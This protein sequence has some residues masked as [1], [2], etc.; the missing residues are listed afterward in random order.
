MKCCIKFAI[1]K[2]RLPALIIC[3]VAVCIAQPLLSQNRSRDRGREY[4]WTLQNTTIQIGFNAVD[5]DESRIG[6]LLNTSVWSITPFPSKISLSKRIYGAYHGEISLGFSH[7]K[8]LATEP[9]YVAPFLYYFAEFNVRYHFDFFARYGGVSGGR[10]TFGRK[11]K[12]NL[13]EMS[14]TAYPLIGAGFHHISQDYNKSMPTFQLGFG[15]QWWLKEE[16]FALNIQTIGKFGL[17]VAPPQRIGNLIHYS[18]G[19]CFYYGRVPL[20]RA[21]FGAKRRNPYGN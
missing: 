16:V 20:F 15:A 19:L 5:D 18:A 12:F 6:E 9:K 14:L 13:S 7:L 1:M 2:S 11:S 17:H 10:R 3:V 8:Q 21:L 4:L